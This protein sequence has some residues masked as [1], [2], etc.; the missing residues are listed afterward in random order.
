MV[1][2]VWQYVYIVGE[3]ILMLYISD[4]VA[5]SERIESLLVRS[6]SQLC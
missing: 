5:A 6:G 1:V 3:I 2:F 4:Y